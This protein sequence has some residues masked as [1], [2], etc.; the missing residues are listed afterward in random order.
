[1]WRK[2]YGLRAGVLRPGG[3]L[4][5]CFEVDVHVA[6]EKREKRFQG[7]ASARVVLCRLR[8]GLPAKYWGN[9]VS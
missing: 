7:G 8:L 5:V 9:R 1:M 6:A 2:A 3:A 4:C